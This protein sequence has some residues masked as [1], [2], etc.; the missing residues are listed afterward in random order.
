LALAAH[1]AAAQSFAP[2]AK[3]ILIN[4]F[5]TGIS[6]A[7]A[8]H[9]GAQGFAVALAARN[10]DRLASGVKALEAKGIHAAGFKTDLTDLTAI[11]KLI[12][13]VKE[14]LGQIDVV[15]WNAYASGAGDFLT[16]DAAEV[17]APFDLAV[18]S[19]IATVQASLADLRATKG[20]V[21]VTNG[22][23]GALDPAVDAMGVTWKAMG[24]SV[25]N[26]AK[27]KTV[28]L[29]AEQLKPDGVYVGEVSVLQAVK[30][31]AWDSGQATL[32]ASTIAAKFWQIYTERK[33][34]SVRVG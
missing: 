34:L 13:D 4:G 29:L 11:P 28:R 10:T 25:A 31:T 18:T 3:T 23:L 21:L 6:Q 15:Q 19:L 26:A 20:A 7:I 33:E 32:E 2:M 8:E 14:K 17:R 22:G 1:R 12:K 16:N 5:G 27:H 9:F 30:G 24:L